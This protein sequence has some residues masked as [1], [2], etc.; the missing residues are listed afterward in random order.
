LNSLSSEFDLTPAQ[1]RAVFGAVRAVV[2]ADGPA[3]P[4]GARLL[5]VAGAALELPDWRDIPAAQPREV[6]RVF[7]QPM[8]RRV[9]AEALLIP[10][11]IDE[12]VTPRGEAVVREFAAALEV[13]SHWVRLLPALRKGN[14]L[15]I[16]RQ[17]FRRSP[18][19]R[20]LFRRTLA[21]EG[22]GG[23]L[24]TLLYVTFGWFRDSGTSSR[25]RSLAE[26]TPGSLGRQL[27][28]DT[29]SRGLSF[30]G[31]RGGIPERMVHHDLMHVV[32]GY[33]TDPAGECELAG[34]Y[35]GYCAEDAYTF[36]II[37]LST[38][39]LGLPVSPPM[40][41]PARGAFDPARVLA[42]FLRGR[43]LQVDIMGDWDYWSLMPLPIDEVRT[44]L[45][46]GDTP[47][48]A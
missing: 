20:R 47:I 2:E 1:A 48:R 5:E 26:L 40:V 3:K 31:E 27:H 36:I 34:F 22:V 18:D 39:H 6:A 23:L 29:V 4:G 25:F 45:G 46:I 14:V 28:D 13:D 8:A 7:D 41:L 10:A 19:A 44:R 33:G 30:P 37:V 15:A 11:C 42:A 24:R 17:L 12:V 32:N 35:T 9:L 16:K 21:E 43:R 38:F